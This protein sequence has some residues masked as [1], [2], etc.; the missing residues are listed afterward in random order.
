M[1]NKLFLL[2]LLAGAAMFILASC[3]K[4]RDWRCVCET[5]NGDGF[6][7]PLLGLK[8]SDAKDACNAFEDAGTTCDLESR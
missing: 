2:L 5:G 7:E 4:E 3:S 6:T 1:K 8:K